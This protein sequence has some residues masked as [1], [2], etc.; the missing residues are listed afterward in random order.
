MKLIGL[1]IT[2]TVIGL[3]AGI[4]ENQ[5][6]AAHTVTYMVSVVPPSDVRV[7]Y[8]NE[9]GGET[10]VTYHSEN[11]STWQQDVI[12]PG[13]AS[14][15]VISPD[16]LQI[17]ISILHNMASGPRKEVKRGASV[18]GRQNPAISI[19]WKPSFWFFWLMN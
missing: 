13:E 11:T 12:V 9:G 10:A 7:S 6:K 15:S 5:E 8:A 14:L 18:S 19:R 3:L 1:L 17:H 16:A 2:F 4:R